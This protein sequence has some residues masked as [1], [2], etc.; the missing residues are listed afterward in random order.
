MKRR[1]EGQNLTRSLPR[2]CPKVEILEKIFESEL[3]QEQ[4]YFLR[5][6]EAQGGEEGL[7][8]SFDLAVKRKFCS[9]DVDAIFE[10]G[11]LDDIFKEY[12]K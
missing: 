10:L 7:R 4:K 5:W 11:V 1:V 8:E 2:V 9:L 6:H 3:Q 12:K